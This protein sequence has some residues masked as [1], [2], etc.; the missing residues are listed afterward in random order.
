MKYAIYIL[1]L[2]ILFSCI[3]KK[4][5]NPKANEKVQIDT[6]NQLKGELYSD[7]NVFTGHGINHLGNRDYNS[8]PLVERI[9]KNDSLFINYWFDDLLEGEGSLKFKKDSNFFYRIDTL[10]FDGQKS[11][12]YEYHT[13]KYVILFEKYYLNKNK[14]DYKLTA[15]LLTENKFQEFEL[16]Q[17]DSVKIGY[18]SKFLSDK[19]MKSEIILNE[20]NIDEVNPRARLNHF[21]VFW[22]HFLCSGK[23]WTGYGVSCQYLN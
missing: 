12:W 8:Y 21:S 6:L 19:S 20:T 23:Y 9:E 10:E 22:H 1:T 2:T 17:A 3:R 11:I 14:L 13:E 16:V 4:E 18:E 15:S 5:S 7:F